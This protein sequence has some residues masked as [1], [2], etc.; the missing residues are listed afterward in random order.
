MKFKE[1]LKSRRITD[2]PQDDFTSDARSD[3]DMPEVETWG[4]LRTYLEGRVGSGMIDKVL[5]AA[6]PVWAA[7]QAKLRQSR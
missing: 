4:E 1:Y 2:T 3:R 7:Y 5:D 6:R